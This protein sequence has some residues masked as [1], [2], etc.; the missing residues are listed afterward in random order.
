MYFVL[1]MYMSQSN[2]DAA[3][4]K[5]GDGI[6]REDMHVQQTTPV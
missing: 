6:A 4:K 2:E 5:G 1:L 3:E